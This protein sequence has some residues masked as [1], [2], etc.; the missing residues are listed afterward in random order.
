MPWMTA[1]RKRNEKLQ[2]TA[3]KRKAEV[4]RMTEGGQQF[5]VKRAAK[6]T[7]QADTAFDVLSKFR[8]ST[9]LDED[10][11]SEKPGSAPP[12]GAMLLKMKKSK[13]GAAIQPTDSTAPGTPASAPA[14]DAT[15]NGRLPSLTCNA[16]AVATRAVATTA[17]SSNAGA[18]AQVRA[19]CGVQ[20]PAPG[21]SAFAQEM[22]AMA[23]DVRDGR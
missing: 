20:A 7:G 9:T 6:A 5:A 15:V 18:L 11:A 21:P 17:T 10:E 13:S 4:R 3:A 2:R 14:A 22:K 23:A 19:R 16:P 12:S 1:T 8:V